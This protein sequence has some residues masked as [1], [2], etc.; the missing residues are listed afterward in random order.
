MFG[1]TSLAVAVAAVLIAAL[2]TARSRASDVPVTREMHME[3]TVHRTPQPGDASRGAAIVAAARALV[4]KYAKAADA[5]RD[6][7]K[8]FLPNVPLPEEHYTNGANAIA[9]ELGFDAN[10]P[11]SIIYRRTANGLIAEGVMYTAPNRSSADAL[12]ARVPLSLAT[13]HR[14]VDFCRAP[15]GTVGDPR[16]GIAGTIDTQAAC[17]AA[18]GHFIPLVFNWMVHVWPTQSDPAKIWAV[19]ADGEHGMGHTMGRGAGAV[20][21]QATLPIS[22]NRLPSQDV[23]AGNV[24]RGAAIFAGNCASCHGAGGVNGPDAPRLAGSGISAGQVAYMV[25]HPRGVDPSSAMPDLGLTSFD[26]ADVAAYVA[27]LSRAR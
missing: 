5:E 16:F 23:A 24:A 9:A 10:R 13:W 25:S 7:Y 4:V 8:K 6:G 14:H 26:I 15:F 21:E 19:D 22:L 18:G 17:D 20:F 27:S 2:A 3:M 1:R 11:T 12:D